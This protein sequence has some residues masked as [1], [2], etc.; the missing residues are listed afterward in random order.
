MSPDPIP[1]PPSSSTPLDPSSPSH[2]AP[3]T[4]PPGIADALPRSR[5]RRPLRFIIAIAL[6]AAAVFAVSTHAADA[7]RALRAGVIASPWLA[8]AAILLPAVNWLI[9]SVSLWSLINRYGRVP[10]RE[11][12]CL[13]G[14]GWLL[15]YLPMR[16]G[17]L[18]RVAYHKTVHGVAIRDSIRVSVWSIGCAA[19]AI[20]ALAPACLLAARL[21][22]PTT[23]LLS[24]A[25]PLVL[26]AAVAITLP[27]PGPR[28]ILF[29]IVLRYLD[30][31]TWT[32]RYM[33]VFALID[34]PISWPG[35]GALACII[36]IP[37]LIPLVGN[38]L[39]LREWTVGAMSGV[40]PE[41]MP[42]SGGTLT[43]P[44]GLA[45]DLL[46]RFA[47]VCCAVPVGLVCS[48]FLSKRKP[49]PR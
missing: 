21:G 3:A 31:L 5:A 41:S 22:D 9:M 29:N 2:P 14:A 48:F 45:A 25:A 26:L 8:A 6:L 23:Q 13:V 12:I 39:G 20:A 19:A 40:L 44:L 38:G 11:M 4:N 1:T 15:N 16:P 46:N 18:G 47:E 17:L 33:V 36:Q 35:A 49:M 30:L 42:A 7:P 10:L 27:R 24:I 34:H 37:M 32:C 28:L 43:T